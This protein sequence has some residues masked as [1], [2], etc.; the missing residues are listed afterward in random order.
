MN[1]PINIK[2]CLDNLVRHLRDVQDNCLLL[3]QRLIDR[4]DVHLGLSLIK[5]GFQHDVSKF[6]GIEWQFLNVYDKKEKRKAA[7]KKG[8]ALAI[9]QHTTSNP[10]HPEFWG[11]IHSMP[12]L[13]L[14]EM[15]C[16][17]KARSNEFGTSL[18]DY[19]KKQ[20]MGKYSFKDSDPVYDKIKGFSELLCST[21][22][23]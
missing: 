14:A 18:S 1:P 3:G 23:E 20:A 12:D 15:V 22:F 17:F 9:H 16:D 4:G 13:Y 21:P 7:F 6:E 2:G 19:I 5:N 10:H 11:S 8:L